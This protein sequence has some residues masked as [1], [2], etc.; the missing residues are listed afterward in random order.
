MESTLYRFVLRHA[1][2]ETTIVCL[3]TLASMP[4]YYLS[5][6][7][8][9]NIMNQAILGR[10]IT[11]P[12]T[13]FGFSLDQIGYLFVLCAWF[14]VMVLINGAMKQ[15]INSYKGRM[16]ERLLRRLRYELITRILRFP[17]P[18]FRKV[19]AGE[20]IPMITSEVEP[21]GGFMG[22]A[23]VQPLIQASTLLTIV[24]FLF[25]QNPIMGIAAISMYPMQ[26]WIIPRLQR[27][28][29]QLG[30]ERVRTMRRV[31]DRIGETVAGV[32]EVRAHGTVNLERAD[33]A[34]RLGVV[35]GI[36]FEIFL[37]KS[38]VKFL[39]N[40]LN[41]MTPLLFYAIGGY[42]VIQGSLT[43]GAL[44]A[45][46]TAYKD[47]TSPWKEL[48]DYYQQSQDSK[49]K[50]EQ[51]TEQFRPEAMIDPALQAPIDA[52][53][54]ALNGPLAVTGLVVPDDGVTGALESTT[55][56]IP[57]GAHVA[58]IGPSGSGKEAFALALARLATP[59]AGSITFA[60][61]DLLRMPEAAFGGRIGHVE[62][63]AYLASGSVRD[64]LTY[65]LKQR[66]VAPAAH[67]EAKMRERARFLA[68]SRRAGNIDLDVSAEWVDWSLA[69]VPDRIA[70]GPRAV[71]VLTAVDLA[72][73]IYQFG[74]RGT[75]DPQARPEIAGQILAARAALRAR[76]ADKSFAN[77]VESFDIK[78]Y[79]TNATLA[80]NL[81]FGTPLDA[82]LEIDRLAANPAVRA[83]LDRDGLTEALVMA[84]RE[85]AIE[86]VD[87]FADVPPGA[88]LFEQFSFVSAEDIASFPALIQRTAGG[89]AA[90]G[91]ADRAR[92]LTL[93]FRLID[94]RHRLGVLDA[95]LKNRVLAARAALRD[96][97][98]DAVDPF[99]AERYNRAATLQDNI[100]FGKVAYGVPKAT[101][102]VGRLIAELLDDLGLR[103]AV[104]EVGLDYQIGVG[105]ARLTVAQRQKLALARN[106]VKRPDLLIVNDALAVLDGAAQARIGDGVAAEMKGRILVWVA[107]TPDVARR[108]DRILVFADGRLV[109]SGT[110]AELDR[111][112]TQFAALAKG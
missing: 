12:T 43:A 62:H 42:L 17:M 71:A 30:K 106:L 88:P 84:G 11:Y 76:L 90:I 14:F 103:P 82:S 69:G 44:T 104:I 2:T 74:L 24:V 51:V 57:A 54:E 40:F 98:A 110:P 70:F 89:F 58:L 96:A 55:T 109:E 25:I 19:S 63:S 111:A 100:L 94:A 23:F 34:E 78:K 87:I 16:G 1:R 28:V 56:E 83:V 13:V 97:L 77:L 37:R 29:N 91:E 48:L 80:E 61:K 31:S 59:S 10:G 105:A 50:Y 38:F 21:L 102:A 45:A 107:R 92:L 66:P 53:Q 46:L 35:F 4:F 81:L 101:Q 49:I 67:D 8:P 22:D 64:A 39:N 18:Y 6:D 95:D 79:N 73:D 33:F 26:G 36:R 9:K 75:I 3:L 47:M 7:I 52:A 60:G 20:M 108:F 65:G 32:R 5:L 112:D 93:P 27:R 72:E 15:Y 85:V 41:Q 99:D 86:M 68:E